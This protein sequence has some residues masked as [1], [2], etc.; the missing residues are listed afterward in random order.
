MPTTQQTHV[1]LDAVS[2]ATTV[3]EPEGPPQ[4]D[5]LLTH[6]TPWSSAVWQPVAARLA[7]THRV[8]LWDMPGYGAS[9]AGPEVAVDLPSQSARL[10]ALARRWSLERP[11]LVAHDIGGAVL[12]GAH[13]RHGLEA[14]SIYLLDAVL[15]TPWGS[16]FFRLVAENA[17]VFTALPERLHAAL[18][19]EYI[20]GADPGLD[21]THIDD[22]ARPWLSVEGQ[23]AFYGQIAQ[24]REDDTR[25]LEASLDRVRARA[26]IAWARGDPWLPVVQGIRL[27]QLIPGADLR[28]FERSGH[29]APLVE[30]GALA[31]DLSAWLAH[32]QPRT[33][34]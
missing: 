2:V 26:R 28:V 8:F 9:T 27:A 19:R 10:A 7:A 4:G 13:L 17:D 32:A 12:M 14:A 16:P 15:L 33:R 3:L 6:G 30:T 34:A 21:A 5:V 22:L 23:A 18:V 25:P 11:H 1:R 29:L 24:L 20:S 31:A